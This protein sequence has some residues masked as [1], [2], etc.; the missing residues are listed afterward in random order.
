M[1]ILR[2]MT[3]DDLKAWRAKHGYTQRTLADALGVF[4]ETIARWE[5]S[6]RKIPSFLALALLGL[7]VTGGEPLEKGHTKTKKERKV[8]RHGSD[9]PKR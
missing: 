2:I 8:K 1:V 5:T 6:V 4:Q 7:E 3:P 9:L